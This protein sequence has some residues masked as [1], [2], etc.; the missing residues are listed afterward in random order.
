[1]RTKEV[2]NKNP[3]VFCIH[4][5]KSDVTLKMKLEPFQARLAAEWYANKINIRLQNVWYVHALNKL[6]ET[7]P[8]KL[9]I[10][11]AILFPLK[12]AIRQIYFRVRRH[13]I[14]EVR[15]GNIKK[16]DFALK[17]ECL[18][19]KIIDKV[20]GDIEICKKAMHYC[21]DK[22]HLSLRGKRERFTWDLTNPYHSL[23]GK[24]NI[25]INLPPDDSKGKK[26]LDIVTKIKS[27]YSYY[28]EK[29]ME[30]SPGQ[31]P[32]FFTIR[33]AY[34]TIEAMRDKNKSYKDIKG[35]LSFCKADVKSDIR[36]IK[37]KISFLAYAG[38]NDIFFEYLGFIRDFQFAKN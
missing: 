20:C 36:N 11:A 19:K 13:Y 14:N 2:A 32:N 15:I 30:S 28:A 23:L 34:N 5:I 35:I 22:G 17:L 3:D 27:S 25:R 29:S 24:V 1:M 12:I 8:K 18:K 21:I 4:F 9:E 16:M 31:V 6:R 26:Y 33:K 10:D 37:R 38:D 7:D